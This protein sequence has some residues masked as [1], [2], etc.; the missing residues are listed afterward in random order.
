[1]E[2]ITEAQVAEFV[3]SQDDYFTDYDGFDKMAALLNNGIYAS[4]NEAYNDLVAHMHGQSPILGRYKGNGEIHKEKV[5]PSCYGEGRWEAE[6]CNGMG[7]CS[8]RG[9]AVDMGTCHVC[10][11]RGY[12]IEGSYNSRANSDFIMRSGACFI[13]SG[14]TSGYWA[15]KPAL[16]Y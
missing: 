16:G 6:C 15:G 4:L 7:G 10:H 14:P 1:M 9:R 8:C 11:G 2:N 12:V 13:G 5:C 3:I